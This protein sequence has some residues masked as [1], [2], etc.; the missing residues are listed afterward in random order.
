[1]AGPIQN[2]AGR[3]TVATGALASKIGNT[4]FQITGDVLNNKDAQVTQ[5]GGESQRTYQ[6]VLKDAEN[7]KINIQHFNEEIM[8]AAEANRISQ[9]HVLAKQNQQNI[10]NER[11]SSL[12]GSK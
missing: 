4:V 3:A 5:Q 6:D 2:A 7:N 8:R 12:G 1:M 11:Y 9:K 10:Y